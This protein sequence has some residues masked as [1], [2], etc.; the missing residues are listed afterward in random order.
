M[1]TVNSTRLLLVSADSRLEAEVRRSL[2]I[3]Q[4]P[5]ILDV[6]RSL[7]TLSDAIWTRSAELLLVAESG[8][9]HRSAERIAEEFSGETKKPVIFLGD[10]PGAL[11]GLHLLRKHGS[12]CIAFADLHRLPLAIEHSL[13]HFETSNT[14]KRLQ[15]EILR[16]ADAVGRNQKLVTI[17][18]LAGSIAHEINNPLESITNLIYLTA[19]E[20][21]LPAQA[22]TYLELAQKEL[23]RVVEISKQTLTFNRETASPV[24]VCAPDLIEEVLGLYRRRVAEKH[25]SVEREYGPTAHVRVFPGEIRQVFSNLIGNALEAMEPQGCLRIRVRGGFMPR[26]RAAQALRIS[27]ADTG[28]GIPPHVLARL[29]EPFFTTKGQRGTG[30]GLW[31]TR[32]I[33][34]RHGGVLRLRSRTGE[35]HGTTFTIFLPVHF[36]P[37]ALDAVGKDASP[38]QD[39]PARA[40]EVE[41]SNGGRHWAANGDNGIF[42]GRAIGF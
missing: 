3:V 42:R 16:A 19:H 38:V 17:G 12:E 18:R 20:P 40:P 39:T 7:T 35:R 24:P 30:L 26:D 15:H 8:L 4:M 34:Q 28:S 37:E 27:I 2:A 14:E 31:V 33:I 22:R 41:T 10:P 1:E 21:G 11:G 9:P 32:S 5:A 29:G 36:M 23:N 25:I 6:C 13:R